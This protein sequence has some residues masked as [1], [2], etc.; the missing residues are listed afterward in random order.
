MAFGFDDFAGLFDPISDVL[1]TSG[2]K[3][4][5]LLQQEPE[6]LQRAAMLAALAASG[7]GILAAAPGAAGAGASAALVTPEVAALTPE[8]L[9]TAAPEV[10][11]ADVAT[12]AGIDSFYANSADIANRYAMPSNFIGEGQQVAGIGDDILG[13]LQRNNIGVKG[14]DLS[15]AGAE[16]PGA[17]Y[18]YEPGNAFF[19]KGGVRL[20]PTASF[21]TQFGEA[22]RNIARDAD[23]MQSGQIGSM[24]TG[25]G[26][27]ANRM[28]LNRIADI[29]SQD[30]Q[31]AAS[32]KTSVQRVTR[33]SSPLSKQSSH[34]SLQ[35]L[36]TSR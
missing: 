9:A 5:G 24:D 13:V 25:I 23:F 12:N 3:G 29:G 36:K 26:D 14:V 21:D 15:Q 31:L 30:T 8:V 35:Q 11:G 22:S 2:R 33:C 4:V 1:G 10:I 34:R 28:E 18:G 32:T 20:E 6:D 17:P 27:A 7:Y 16:F 19:D